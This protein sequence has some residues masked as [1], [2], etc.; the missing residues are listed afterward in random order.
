MAVVKNTLYLSGILILIFNTERTKG[1]FDHLIWCLVKLICY[2]FYLSCDQKMREITKVSLVIGHIIVN[3][4]CFIFSN[5]SKN[6]ENT[7]NPITCTYFEPFFKFLNRD[8][9]LNVQISPARLL[10]GN[11]IQPLSVNFPKGKVIKGS[12]SGINA[13]LACQLSFTSSKPV[14]FFTKVLFCDGRDNW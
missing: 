11:E 8:S 13:P 4:Y 5:D 12:P 2:Q 6:K 1:T 7:L 10:G 14:S 9:T 3:I